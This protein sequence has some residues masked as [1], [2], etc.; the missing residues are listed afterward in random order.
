MSDGISGKPVLSAV[1][2]GG[3]QKHLTE[4]SSP[5]QQCGRATRYVLHTVPRGANLQTSSPGGALYGANLQTQSPGGALIATDVHRLMGRDVTD[6]RNVTSPTHG[7]G[8]TDTRY[9]TDTRDETDT[10]D[11]TKVI[12]DG[13]DTRDGTE[14]YRHGRPLELAHVLW[15]GRRR[16]SLLSMRASSQLSVPDVPTLATRLTI[17]SRRNAAQNRPGLSA[18]RLDQ[19]LYITRGCVLARSEEVSADLKNR[20]N[21]LSFAEEKTKHI[22]I[23]V[24]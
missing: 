11:G 7:T 14:Q 23:T 10:G 16:P 6:T 9:G 20:L 18:F 21:T 4:S 19:K 3:G 12:L 22:G 17:L 15:M 24:I 8:R 13:T 5:Q 2:V 1:G